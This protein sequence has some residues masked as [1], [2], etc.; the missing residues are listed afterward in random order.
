MAISQLRGVC[1]SRNVE[2]IVI[3]DDVFDSPSTE[4]LSLHRYRSFHRRFTQDQDL[5]RSV[6]WVTGR[7]IETLPHQPDD[8]EE[9]QIDA[10]WKSNWR[11]QVGGRK[12]KQSHRTAFHDLFREHADNLLGMLDDVVALFS[13]FNDELSRSVT[14]YGTDFDSDQLAKAE[15]IVLDFF[16][17]RDLTIDQAFDVASQVVKDTID[18][19]KRRTRAT[20]S[21]LLVSSR[22]DEID[23]TE[24]RASTELMK[25]RFRFFSKDSLTA[26]STENMANLHDVVAAL[27]RT[28]VVERLLDDWCQGATA[29]IQ[30]V[31][32][33]IL[34]LD[35]SDLTYL[36][37]F[38]LSHEGTSVPNYLKWFLTSLLGANVA[39]KLKQQAWTHAHGMNFA[40]VFDPDGDLD[41]ESL[42]GTFDGPTDEIAHAYGDIVFDLERAA[43]SQAST[44]RSDPYRDLMEGDLFVRP[45]GRDRKRLEGAPVLLVLTPGCDLRVRGGQQS[46]FAE[47]VV[48][49]PGVLTP[50][51]TEDPNRNFAEG[52]FIRAQD[53]G[54]SRLLRIDWDY[55]RP[56]SVDWEEVA[57]NGPGKGF[58]LLGRI[59]DLYFHKVRE[60]FLGRLARIGTE[61]PP[62]YPH[63]LAGEVLLMMRE[64]RRK[65]KEL[66]MS[67]S[68]ADGFLWEI[69][70]VKGSLRRNARP[71]Y[72]YQV[73]RSFLQ[74]LNFALRNHQHDDPQVTHAVCDATARLDDLDTFMALVRPGPQGRR[75]ASNSVEIKKSALRSEARKDSQARILIVPFRD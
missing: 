65:R 23:I 59:R 68:R 10:L 12:I 64:G 54:V 63:A 71:G 30:H 48:L 8:L 75:G 1:D 3:V 61:I 27:D 5:R 46:P 74:S 6:A 40:N 60:A 32:D 53:Q 47:A 11:P 73:S 62:V 56:T 45:R 58:K 20:P 39:S 66:V 14:V 57:T 25:S 41:S 55:H 18:V 67:F 19:A 13:L 7:E 34:S 2:R 42:M 70:P 24:F 50:M 16:L 72:F 69:G 15:I 38:R 35:V 51:P 4:G 28:A 26:T 9:E 22:P 17:G 43:S 29:A 44:P 31:R 49:L 52:S 36:D 37:C 33:T 21:F